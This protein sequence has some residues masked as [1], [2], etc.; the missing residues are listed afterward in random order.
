MAAG[1]DT[2]AAGAGAA[3]WKLI[4]RE[5]EAFNRNRPAVERTMYKGMARMMLPFVLVVLAI[6]IVAQMQGATGITVIVLALAVLIG[7]G[8]R[9]LV[10]KP[11]DDLRDRNRERLLPV[12][13]G[14][15]DDFRYIRD[16]TPDVM[17]WLHKIELI[18]FHSSLHAGTITGRHGG[19]VFTLSETELLADEGRRARSL[20][21]GTMFHF[22]REVFFPGTFIAQSRA[23]AAAG[24]LFSDDE[25]GDVSAPGGEPSDRILFRST[26][27][28]AAQALL[29]GR[30]AGLPARL[31]AAW[32]DAAWSFALSN[33]DCYLFIPAD[34]RIFDLP[35]IGKDIDV[36]RDIRPM[37]DEM[38]WF[39]KLM[40]DTRNL[41]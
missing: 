27:P 1:K 35:P 3:R 17:P 4:R 25:L 29:K 22:R 36:E 12:I 38:R 34:T 40:K 2:P 39:L 16:E 21:E 24:A 37:T 31:D 14:Q 9:R 32:P 6:A 20:F 11:L 13:Y 33:H 7:F 23:D 10:L 15:I 8:L 19:T 41:R 28:Q 5:V 30:F 26:N 18:P